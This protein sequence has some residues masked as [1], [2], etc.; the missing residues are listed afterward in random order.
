LFIDWEDNYLAHWNTDGVNWGP[1]PT[2]AWMENQTYSVAYA[3]NQAGLSVHFAGDFP[4]NLTGYDLLVIAAYWAVE[5][6]D[7]AMVQN[8]IANG[9]GVVLLSG[10]PEFFRCYSKT[11]WTYN[12]STA[13]SS[14]GMDEIFGC[15]GN[16]FNT[17]G[18]ANVTVNNPFG[19][20]LQ[21]GDTLI[22]GAG[23][24]N[25]AVLNP[26]NGSQ[27]VATWQGLTYNFTLQQGNSTQ[28][29]VINLQPAFAYTYPYG[30]GRVYYQS[31][32]V[33][34]DPPLQIVHKLPLAMIMAA[35]LHWR[36][37]EKLHAR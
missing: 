3:L 8:F 12:C 5:P 22:E 1:W 9:G 28:I 2:Q 15:D 23:Q 14:I 33:P 6:S 18:Y 27:V 13:S 20:S 37:F 10:V 25:A 24:S 17:G 31:T 19:T 35:D 36:N 11:W 7:L 21:A 29:V 30:Q 4:S 34:V 32:F 26:Y 16:Y